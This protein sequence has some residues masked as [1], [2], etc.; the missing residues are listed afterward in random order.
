MAA[1]DVGSKLDAMNTSINAK[2]DSIHSTISQTLTAVVGIANNEHLFPNY[3]LVLPVENKG[4]SMMNPMSW[5]TQKVRVH[6]NVCFGRKRN[7]LMHLACFK[8][9]K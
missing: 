1:Q 3:V 2:L 8:I 9:S 7:A 5:V 6:I 4:G